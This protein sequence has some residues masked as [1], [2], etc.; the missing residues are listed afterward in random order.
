MDYEILENITTADIAFRVRAS[1]VSELFMKGAGALLSEM[2]T[3]ISSIKKSVSRNGLLEGNDLSI[4]YF[5]FLNELIFF[6]DAES[7]LL[8]PVEVN[9]SETEGTFFCSYTFYGEKI[10]R[11]VHEFKV[12]VKAVTLHNLKVYESNGLF[13]AETVLDV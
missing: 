12:E 2:I 9:V 10:N 8:V 11:Q 6:R 5:E 3:D 1:S 7:L 13:I 4:L